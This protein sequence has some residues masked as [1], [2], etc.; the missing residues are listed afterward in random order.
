MGSLF[1]PEVFHFPSRRDS[2][3]ITPQEPT[4]PYLIQ[5]QEEGIFL[6]GKAVSL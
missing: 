5:K 1:R 3:F 2:P 6:C 4:L